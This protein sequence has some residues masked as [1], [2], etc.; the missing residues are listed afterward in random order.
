MSSC[1]IRDRNV[2]FKHSFC[3]LLIFY[4]F[5]SDTINIRHHD[6]DARGL[7]YSSS[8]KKNQKE[9]NRDKINKISRI[10]LIKFLRKQDRNS[11]V[12]LQII[13]LIFYAPYTFRPNVGSQGDGCLFSEGGKETSTRP[14]EMS[15]VTAQV[16]LCSVYPWKQSRANPTVLFF[17]A[18]GR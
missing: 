15:K 17:F 13:T 16:T 7:R 8:S 10:R 5:I 11:F 12:N 1:A 18:R 3:A 6:K 2:H 4:S 9:E 14:F